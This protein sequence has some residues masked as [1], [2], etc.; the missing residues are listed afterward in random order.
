MP[1]RH[2]ILAA[3]LAELESLF[4]RPVSESVEALLRQRPAGDKV[5]EY[6]ELAF[7]NEEQIQT[8]RKGD[9][10]TMVMARR[11]KATG[12]DSL[13]ELPAHEADPLGDYLRTRTASQFKWLL[14]SLFAVG[15]PWI[16]DL[17]CNVGREWVE[18]VLNLLFT[19]RG[20]ASSPEEAEEYRLTREALLRLVGPFGVSE[21]GRVVEDAVPVTEE[22]FR[23]LPRE[24]GIAHFRLTPAFA[25]PTICR[26]L[27]ALDLSPEAF[28]EAGRQ[29][30]PRLQ[31]LVRDLCSKLRSVEKLAYP[32]PI[33]I[34]FI[35]T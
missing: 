5:R 15:R 24:D 7:A 2:C 19:Q 11:M 6:A 34:S 10:E 3:D 27:A 1:P 12:Q 28:L 33:L 20:F 26:T 4:A 18:E 13:S 9:R 31:Q 16:Q 17:A 23:W 29:E 21:S 32:R 25:V 30:V 14:H 22:A 8:L 35:G